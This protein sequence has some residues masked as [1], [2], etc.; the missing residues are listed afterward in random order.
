MMKHPKI[1]LGSSGILIG[2]AMVQ[3]DFHR[4]YLL[5][6]R[7]LLLEF[8]AGRCWNNEDALPIFFLQRHALELLIKD[9]LRIIYQLMHVEHALDGQKKLPSKNARK[10]FCK[11][12]ILTL[13][14]DLE[15]K[16]CFDDVSNSEAIRRLE[17]LVNT[18]HA[19]DEKSTWAR[20]LDVN[21]DTFIA[22]SIKP[23][24]LDLNFY[25][26]EIEGLSNLLVGDDDNF[27]DAL[28]YKYSSARES[29]LMELE[30]NNDSK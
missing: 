3:P 21:K 8:G 17:N 16:L 29:C 1:K 11:H 19:I 5:A 6:A 20:Y 25:Q 18:I 24:K 23:K 14:R 2:K 15:K 30:L 10:R 13:Y 12:D 27:R 28:M 22:D 26:Q 7:K 9:C 4:A